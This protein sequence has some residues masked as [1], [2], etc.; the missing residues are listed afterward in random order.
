MKKKSFIQ[1]Q[2]NKTITLDNKNLIIDFDN[3]FIENKNE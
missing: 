3:S 1:K 2:M